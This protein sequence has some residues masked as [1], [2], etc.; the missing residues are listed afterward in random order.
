MSFTNLLPTLG[1]GI[2]S[3][4]GILLLFYFIFTGS[5]LLLSQGIPQ[6]LSEFFAA[7]AANDLTAAYALTTPTFQKRTSKKQFTKFIKTHQL[8]QYKRL[9]LPLINTEGDR[10]SLNLAIELL[11]GEEVSL[12]LELAKEGK[13]W[14]IEG[15]GEGD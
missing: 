3:I 6:A 8:Q 13:T 7:I 10:C 4:F 12:R 2:A 14:A 9:K 5:I 1:I 11:S 15:W